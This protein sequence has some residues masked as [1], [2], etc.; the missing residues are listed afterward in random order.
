MTSFSE[1]IDGITPNGEAHVP[2][3]WQQGRTTYGGLSAALCVAGALRTLPDLPPLRSA[4]FTF[5]GPAAGVLRIAP[6][7]LRT[8]KNSVFVAVDLQADSG[9]ATRATLSF[10]AAR[11]SSLRYRAHPAPSVSPPEACADFFAGGTPPR[12]AA[13]FDVLR[14]GG[15]APL[16]RAAE[17]DLLV[18][19]RHRDPAARRGLVGLIALADALPPAAFSMFAAPAPISTVTW[20]IDV[21]DADAANGGTGDGWHLMQSRGDHV[22][23]GYT[24]QSMTAWNEAFLPVLAARQVV[25]IFV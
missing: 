16:S 4:Q 10:G 21:L 1:I 22:A 19:F 11:A 7:V 12:F 17:P 23:D 18:W 8:G 2:E 9:L 20:S 15:C 6:S 24:S 13:Q 25:A 14:A 5:I 3:D